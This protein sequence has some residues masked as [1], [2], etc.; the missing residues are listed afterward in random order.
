VAKTKFRSS[1]HIAISFLLI[2]G[3]QSAFASDKTY[4][5]ERFGTTITF[6]I[7]VFATQ[8]APP[9]NGDGARFMAADGALLAIWG[10]NNALDYSPTELAD[11]IAAD[12]DEVTYRSVGARWLVVSGF[13]D[14][15][16]VY[17]RAEFG[18][19]GVIHT[20][21]LHY[22]IALRKQYDRLAGK[23]AD[24]LIGP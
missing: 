11:L 7:E 22:P 12:I 17:H 14:K 18:A 20:M 21:E 23:I 16:I 8:D 24:S 19:N 4:V 9:E 15:A 5:N 3:S 13:D 1:W 2:F 6:P 10:Q